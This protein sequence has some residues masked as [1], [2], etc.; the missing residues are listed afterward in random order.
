MLLVV[1]GRF[2]AIVVFKSQSGASDIQQMSDIGKSSQVSS[3]Q[4]ICCQDMLNARA[5][6]LWFP[7]SQGEESVEH[8]GNPQA[9]RK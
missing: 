6:A 9:E 5:T 8:P 1:S 3:L 7:V 4:S 2:H